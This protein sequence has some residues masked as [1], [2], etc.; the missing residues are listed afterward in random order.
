MARRSGFLQLV[1]IIL[2]EGVSLE[3]ELIELG[4]ENNFVDKTGAWYSYKGDRMGQGKDN[5]RQY[6]KD[7]PK[8]AAEIEASIRAVA[9][10]S[11]AAAA[12]AV[13]DD[14]DELEEA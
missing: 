10:T 14:L 12:R 3:S 8:I 5:V 6:L 11:N 4:V 13:E 2:N 1:E 9:I 7:N